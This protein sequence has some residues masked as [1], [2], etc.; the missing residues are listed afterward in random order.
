MIWEHAL[1]QPQVLELDFTR[2]Y[3]STPSIHTLPEVT[4]FRNYTPL[5]STCSE[6]RS[7]ALQTYRILTQQKKYPSFCFYPNSG[8][9]LAR[10]LS[11]L[12]IFVVRGGDVDTELRP[13][14]ASIRVMSLD[15]LVAV[16]HDSPE[17]HALHEDEFSSHLKASLPYVL[18]NLAGLEELIILG[19]PAT[20][21]LAQRVERL[22][23]E[24]LGEQRHHAFRY[25][26]NLQPEWHKP[27]LK[28]VP[29]ITNL[30]Y[31]R[32]GYETRLAA[33]KRRLLE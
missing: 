28:K 26:E 29:R 16:S 9:F 31:T 7:I 12:R 22:L 15:P 23:S 30:M 11:H 6:S 4:S 20:S 21:A 25:D 17:G 8:I 18:C 3:F 32:K 13:F 14:L 10:G 24:V 1:S 19:F 27:M 2:A 5:L 33:M